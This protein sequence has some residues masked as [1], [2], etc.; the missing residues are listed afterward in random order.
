MPLVPWQTEVENNTDRNME[1]L[2]QYAQPSHY[3]QRSAKGQFAS[4][5]N[6]QDVSK[7]DANK[8]PMTDITIWKPYNSGPN[9]VKST[10]VKVN[11][12]LS[13]AEQKANNLMQ[14]M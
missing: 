10:S 8:H 14:R 2:L 4:L 9:W 13:Q 11:I 1:N 12:L 5:L 7:E 3:L 6:S